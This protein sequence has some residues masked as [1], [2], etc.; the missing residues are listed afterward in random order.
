M[1]VTAP[2]VVYNLAE[3]LMRFIDTLIVGRLGAVELAAVG[4]TAGIIF[5]L[6][7]ALIGVLSI[8]AVLIAQ[9]QGASD[10]RLM[11]QGVHQGLWTSLIIFVPVCAIAYKIDWILYAA[12]QD[13]LVIEIAKKYAG[14]V[15]WSILP[16]M[17]FTVLR[18]FLATLGKAKA[19]I[20]VNIAATVLN[21]ILSYISA[22][23][24]M[25]F[26]ALGVAG[27]GYATS[28]TCWL[29]F[30]TLLLYIWQ[31]KE[32]RSYGLFEKLELPSLSI[33][34]KFFRLGLPAT[35]S[36]L[37]EHGLFN[38]VA[39][40]MGALGA[41]YLAATQI[42]YSYLNIG[43]VVPY[44]LAQAATLRVAYSLGAGSKA[45][46]HQSGLLALLAGAVFMVF[47]TCVLW[48]WPNSI[49]NLFVDT[50]DMKNYFVLSITM[51]S[52]IFIGFLQIFDGMQIVATGALCG[53]E[54]T[55]VPFI[56]GVLCF[57]LIGLGG[58]SVLS[59]AFDFGAPGIWTGLCAGLVAAAILLTWR[60]YRLT[61]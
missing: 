40:I 19:I 4:L 60:F 24:K 35:G 39:L 22:Y 42:A 43:C 51:E 27:V 55:K 1:L 30:I 10:S 14:A 13:P 31:S 28:L 44:A 56:M 32:L 54:D 57:W 3:M 37:L 29:M 49:V 38:A 50:T 45:L 18:N 23:G 25:G 15:V 61:R 2:L 16:L 6:F 58:G 5:N 17:W 26:P 8:S 36:S 46:A 47:M 53:L 9:G 34:K 48:L 7:D 59:F 33:Q 52:L 41:D 20:L 11:S 12:R 21:L